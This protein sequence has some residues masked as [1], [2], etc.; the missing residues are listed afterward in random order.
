MVSVRGLLT[1]A[2]VVA[3]TVTAAPLAQARD[4]AATAKPEPRCVVIGPPTQNPRPTPSLPPATATR[5]PQAVVLQVPRVRC[6]GNSPEQP[7]S[8]NGGGAAGA[9]H[10]GGAVAGS[11]GGLPFT[12]FD[13]VAALTASGWLMAAGALLQRLGRRRL[14]PAD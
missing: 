14:R 5:V 6:K 2:L 1:A 9:G 8:G 12:G 7:I 11:G 13:V 3:A 4:G 10:G